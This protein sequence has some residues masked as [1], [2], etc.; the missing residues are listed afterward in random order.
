MLFPKPDGLEGE[1]A[2]LAPNVLEH[3]LFFRPVVEGLCTYREMMVEQ[4]FTFDQIFEMHEL[5][6]LKAYDE[7]RGATAQT[8]RE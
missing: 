3:W 6:D 2:R 5:L 1:R 4:I 8:S 7:A